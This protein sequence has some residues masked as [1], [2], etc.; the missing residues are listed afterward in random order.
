MTILLSQAFQALACHKME[1]LIASSNTQKVLQLRAMVKELL[2]KIEVRSLFDFPQFKLSDVWQATLSDRA[3]I[4]GLQAAKALQIPC[5]CEQWTLSIPAFDLAPIFAGY[6][7][8]LEQ[9]KQILKLLEGANESQRSSYFESCMCWVSGDSN[10]PKVHQATARVEG[11]IAESERGKASIDFENIFIKYDY[12]KTLAEL[13]ESV[14]L[15]ISARRKAL[16]KL[17]IYLENML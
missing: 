9:T 4:K 11:Q 7:N 14:R 1:L 17:A 10:A 8:R 16:E 3:R 6:S 13:S 15:R 12:Q 5:L 2:P